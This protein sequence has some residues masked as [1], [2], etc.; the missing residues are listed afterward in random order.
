MRAL[1]LA[2]LISFAA[3]SE[4]LYFPP[5]IGVNVMTAYGAVGD[6]VTDDTAAISAAVTE[7]RVDG[8]DYFGQPRTVFLPRGTYLL[9]STIQEIGAEV[10][11]IGQGPGQTVLKLKDHAAGFGDATQPRAVVQTIGGNMAFRNH[12][13]HLSIDTGS[14]N[15]GAYG[16]QFCASNSGSIRDV[17]IRSGD[18][19][20]VAG[21]AMGL[22]WPGPLLVKNL[23]VEGFD[24]GLDIGYPE[25]GIVMEDL[26]LIGCRRAGIRTSDNLL[27]IRHLDTAVA[28]PAIL[29]TGNA[30]MVTLLGGNLQHGP[31]TACAIEHEGSGTTYLRGVG[32]SGYQALVKQAGAVVAGVSGSEFVSSPAQ[33]LFASPTSSLGLPIAETPT[34]H[35]HDPAQWAR[36]TPAQYGDTASLQP[37][38]NAGKNT[39]YFSAGA[40]LFYALTVVNVPAGVKKI[41]AFN[42]TI[43]SDTGTGIVFTVSE[44]SNDP[45]VIEGFT[46]NTTI[47][48]RCARCVVLA[49][50]SYTYTATAAAGDLFI[51]DVVTDVLTIQAGKKVWARQL[52]TE[53]E[54][55]HTL[56][57]GGDL[58][59]LGVK[60]EGHGTV[61]TTSAS[62][63]SEVLGTL[64]YP[65]S[66]FPTNPRPAFV[67]TDG[68]VSLLYGTS[69]SI[70]NGAYATQVR[71]TRGTDTRSLT[72]DPNA[73][74]RYAMP[75]FTGY[76]AAAAVALAVSGISAAAGTQS[77][78]T[79]TTD[80]AG[81]SA[82]W[83]ATAG[84]GTVT[85]N[86]NASR[87]A[88]TVSAG[89]SA[90]GTYTLTVQKLLNGV[91][92]GTDS[93]VVTV[94]A[95]GS[96]SI[97]SGDTGGAP[98]PAPAP[99][100]NSGGGG[101]C[102]VGGLAGMLLLV[103]SGLA[104]KRRR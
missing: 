33:S 52:D 36:V 50:G 97:P 104:L 88:A 89:F 62:G 67:S 3:A 45:L 54:H 99:A 86:R 42:S 34:W 92:L 25:Y 12:L 35:D 14:G 31:A 19:A 46:N 2:L 23:R 100:G 37:A 74:G 20:G 29:T 69:S 81:G 16:V 47:D 56:N 101:G 79:L 64:L 40:Y 98:A 63:R 28:G 77:A 51:E 91:S 72:T 76:R 5:D 68:S 70:S 83:T 61:V 44:P 73:V 57:Q 53:G 102:G 94:A 65:S 41:C 95:D 10:M 32:S 27:A 84:P 59:L 85:F 78:M 55:D 22:A 17:S 80:V 6:G 7:S 96:V 82:F 8:G 87:E 103:F 1:I 15:P 39:V 60:T 9:S 90:P 66:S 13:W 49:D 75:L 18:G 11:L 43:N 38:L 93:V 26:T 30:A 4:A 48:H 24:F 21:V 71:E 58:W